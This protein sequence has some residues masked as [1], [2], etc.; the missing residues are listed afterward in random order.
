MKQLSNISV[1]FKKSLLL[2]ALLFSQSIIWA[3]DKTVDVNLNVNKGE[4]DWYAQPWILVV[5][6]AVF[7]IIIVALLRGKK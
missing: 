7:I 3:Q 6:G 5:G 2:I 1:T 4:N